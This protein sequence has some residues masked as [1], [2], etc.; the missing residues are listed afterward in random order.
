MRNAPWRKSERGVKG[1]NM[2]VVT[3]LAIRTKINLEEYYSP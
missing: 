1:S 3:A 2:E